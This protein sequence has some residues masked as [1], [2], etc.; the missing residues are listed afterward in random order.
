MKSAFTHAGPETEVII[1]P[2]GPDKSW[3]RA[4]DSLPRSSRLTIHPIAQAHG[5]VARNQGLAMARGK[6]VRFLDDD[7]Y[8]QPAATDQIA[9]LERSGA[10]FASGLVRNEDQ[11]GADLG[12][13]R[14]PH[15]RDFVCAAVESSAFTLPV[16]NLFRRDSLKSVLWDPSVNRLQDNAWMLDLAIC[17]EW[18]WQH[19]DQVVGTWFQHDA[20][21]TSVSKVQTQ[22]DQQ[23]TDRLSQLFETLAASGRL[24][25]DRSKAIADA[26]WRYAHG[27]FPHA[28]GHWTRIA[29]KALNISA[30]SRPH[31]PPYNLPVIRRID[32]VLIEW[33]LVPA[34][35]A[36]R[37]GVRWRNSLTGSDYRRRL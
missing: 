33:S 35:L 3:E 6:Y 13:L 4:L 22:L 1:V 8:L 5:N 14:F 30:T 24:T 9:L 19:L 7:D 16:G 26:L 37:T 28:P 36:Y 31:H 21:R 18:Q 2:N 20:P 10:E 32:P 17:R 27:R 29:R 11:E 25:A 23:I 12:L 15:T 34:R